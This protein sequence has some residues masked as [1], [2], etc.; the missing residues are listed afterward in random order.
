MA[1]KIRLRQQGK[2]NRQTY[3]LVLIDGRSKRDGKYLENLGWYNPFEVQ[4]NLSVNAE[5]V[6]YWLEK[7][8][9]ISDQARSLV[10]RSAPDVMKS[11]NEKRQAVRTKRVA[12]RREAKKA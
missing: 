1:V 7:G 5:R 12:K 9:E 10:A 6:A 11:Y 3:R 2:K 4:N 8:A